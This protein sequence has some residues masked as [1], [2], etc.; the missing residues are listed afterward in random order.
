MNSSVGINAWNKIGRG[1]AERVIACFGMDGQNA[2]GT[3][4][5]LGR[6]AAAQEVHRSYAVDTEMRAEGA[7]QR[8]ADVESPQQVLHL[9][10]RAAIEMQLS[11]RTLQDSR[12][13]RHGVAQI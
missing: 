11:S 4:A 6:V 8:I 13:Q 5:V 9:V 2:G 7:G 1:I 3:F 10:F 12:H